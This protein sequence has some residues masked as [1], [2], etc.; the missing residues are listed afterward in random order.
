M[1]AI[2]GVLLLIIG[3][4]LIY[5]RWANARVNHQYREARFMK[6]SLFGRRPEG[7]EDEDD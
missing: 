5:N 6:G 7:D 3:I 2:L 4:A 1:V